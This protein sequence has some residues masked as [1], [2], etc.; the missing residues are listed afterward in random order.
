MAGW[1][2]DQTTP[3]M[4]ITADRA[5]R[6]ALI[7]G[8]AGNGNP[9]GAGLNGKWQKPAENH[10][11]ANS[12]TRFRLISHSHLHL[13]TSMLSGGGHIIRASMARKIRYGS[14]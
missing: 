14:T 7:G 1:N 4:G 11:T 2:L 3:D 8:S 13:G 6:K 10:A 12:S 5:I 9:I